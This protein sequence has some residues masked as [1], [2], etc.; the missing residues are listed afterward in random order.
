MLMNSVFRFFLLVG[1]I[2]ATAAL[3]LPGFSQ[4]TPSAPPVTTTVVNP[5]PLPPP[6][7]AV[8]VPAPAVPVMTTVPV[9]AP[10]VAEEPLRVER[11]R[12]PPV[13]S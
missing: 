7:P 13:H 11:T 10:T 9:D 2:A 1:L 12:L 5:P 4:E 3:P 8:E 6:T